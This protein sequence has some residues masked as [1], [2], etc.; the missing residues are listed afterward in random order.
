[1]L[2]TIR[3]YATEQLEVSRE[4]RQFKGRHAM[5]FLSFAESAVRQS[6][7]PDGALAGPLGR[8]TRQSAVGAPL[9]YRAAERRAG[10]AS[11]GRAVGGLVRARA[12]HRGAGL[13]SRICLPF[14]RPT[15]VQRPGPWSF[16]ELASLALTQGEHASTWTVLHRSL[17][18]FREVDDQRGLAAALFAAGFVNRLEEHYKMAGGLLQ[19]AVSL[20]RAISTTFMTAAALDH[21]GMI[22]AD[23]QD[24]LA[25]ARG[26][27]EETLALYRTFGLPW[28]IAL[29]LLRSG[30]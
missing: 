21:L 7:G 1:M 9:V 18:L 24:D 20:S 30:S 11:R 28:F 12:H 16:W 23:G 25:A 22:A 27:F 2:E 3:E 5:Y 19:E 8:G 13:F 4:Q 26:Q 10:P 15:A 17:A 14:P 29:L 6:Y